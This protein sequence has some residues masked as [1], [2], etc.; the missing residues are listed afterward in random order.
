M[1]IEMCEGRG[2]G[3]R[4]A[5]GNGWHVICEVGKNHKLVSEETDSKPAKSQVIC[6]EVGEPEIITIPT[7][8]ETR[9]HTYKVMHFFN[10]YT[11]FFKLA[12]RER[13]R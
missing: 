8:Q 7:P 1:Q 5:D 12:E 6:I 11:I 4:L 13:E 10:Y 2:W 9:A 3:R